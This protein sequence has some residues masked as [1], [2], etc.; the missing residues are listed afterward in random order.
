M[1]LITSGNKEARIVPIIR[2]VETEAIVGVILFLMLSHIAIGKV[3]VF[4]PDKNIVTVTS[5]K[6]VIKANNEADAIEGFIWGT[7]ILK[8]TSRGLEP[9]PAAASSILGSTPFKPADR[10]MNTIGIANKVWDNTNP[11]IVLFSLNG[12]KEL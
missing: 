11:K 8:N 7:T 6:D 4:V 9:S 12:A 3:F 2:I 5:S 1:D 10:V